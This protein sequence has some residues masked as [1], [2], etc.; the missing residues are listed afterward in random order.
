MKKRV[1]RSFNDPSIVV[2]T[3]EGQH[4]HQS[5]VMPRGIHAGISPVSDMSALNFP[6]NIHMNNLVMPHQQH[7]NNLVPSNCSHN[8][9]INNFSN[10]PPNMDGGGFGFGSP[11]AMA[12]LGDNGLL[13]DIVPSITRTEDQ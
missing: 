10:G 2:T 13:Q 12:F 5:P 1:E 8:M 11:S 3:Y 9:M 7:L 6:G 4:T